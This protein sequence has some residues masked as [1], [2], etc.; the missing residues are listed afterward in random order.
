MTIPKEITVKI[1]DDSVRFYQK[2]LEYSD[3]IASDKDAVLIELVTDT[4][5]RFKG[6]GSEVEVSVSMTMEWPIDEELASIAG[7]KEEDEFDLEE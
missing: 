5:K 2:Y 3:F 7:I 1:K 4:L 6:D